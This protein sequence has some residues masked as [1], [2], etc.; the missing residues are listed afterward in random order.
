MATL[1][2]IRP[3]YANTT[4]SVKPRVIK[5]EFGD[6]YSQRIADGINSTLAEWSVGWTGR[7]KADIDT[8]EAFFEGLK[9]YIA[10]EWTPE[11]ESVE[12]KFICPEWTRT[13]IWDGNDSIT[14]KFEEVSDL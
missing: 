8:L 2:N 10:F 1:P 11:R 13:Y 7:V 14:A 3:D 5:N 4:K 9:G 6:G 12:K